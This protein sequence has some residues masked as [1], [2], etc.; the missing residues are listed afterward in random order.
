M[1]T[2]LGLLLLPRLCLAGGLPVFDAAANTLGI[3]QQ[4][5]QLKEL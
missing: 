2:L 1:L 4:W 5:T 3:Q